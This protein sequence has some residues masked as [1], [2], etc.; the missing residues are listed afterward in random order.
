M[1]LISLQDSD[2]SVKKKLPQECC[3]SV[4]CVIS[5]YDSNVNWIQCDTCLCWFHVL[6]EGFASS[7]IVQ[8]KSSSTYNCLRCSGAV[9]DLDSVKKR[10]VARL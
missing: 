7:E 6:C 2:F 3:K 8:V 10:N 9:A 4:C 1:I 5:E